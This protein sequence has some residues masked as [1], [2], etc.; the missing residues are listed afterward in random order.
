LK[1]TEIKNFVFQLG[2]KYLSLFFNNRRI[3]IEKK[4]LKTKKKKMKIKVFGM[5]N[6]ILFSWFIS[7]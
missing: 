6:F 7:L 5:Q 3:Q 2:K 1:K 4:K